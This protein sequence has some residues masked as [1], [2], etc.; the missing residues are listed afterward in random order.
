MLDGF[1]AQVPDGWTVTHAR[2]ADILTLG[3]DPEGEFFP[4]GQPRPQVV[5]PGR[6]PTPR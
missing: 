5:V 3:A 1:R 4:D 6:R 2:G